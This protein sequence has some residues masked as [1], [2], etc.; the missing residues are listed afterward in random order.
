MNCHRTLLLKYAHLQINFRDA[1]LVI[2]II[3]IFG[4]TLL[5]FL[6]KGP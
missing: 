5:L 2:N 4:F 3:F 6:I 1:L